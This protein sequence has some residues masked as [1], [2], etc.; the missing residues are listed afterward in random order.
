MGIL[1]Q[2]IAIGLA[3]CATGCYEDFSPKIDATPVL[4]VNSLITAGEPI[5]VEV[6]HSWVYNS[7]E[8]LSDHRVYDA[9]VTIYANGE[10]VG[11]D[12]RPSQGDEI[13]IVA[14]SEKYG[15]AEATVTVPVAIPITATDI[16][17]H[18]LSVWRD[19]AQAMDESVYFNMRIALRVDDDALTEN[20]FRVEYGCVSPTGYEDAGDI[21]GAPH[22][23]YTG[24]SMGEFEYEAEPIFK[25]HVGVF[26][27]VFGDSEEA[28]MLFSDKQF[29]GKS[30]TLNLQ[31]HNCLF[32]VEAPAYDP[33]LYDASLTFTLVT[34]SR[35]YYDR[36]IYIWQ[37]D[38]GA[39][40][41]LGDLGF[42]QPMWGYSNVSTG[43]GVVA[44]RSAYTITLPLKDY[45]QSALKQ[46]SSIPID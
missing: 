10:P 16:N 40:G 35:S 38:S 30:Y 12:F 45:L 36:L 1:K 34:I 19:E 43:A 7:Q 37:R 44:A 46:E 42:A 41:D 31:F 20:F 6:S 5:S 32:Y 33:A 24:L 26:E 25:E 13:R 11:D 4:C 29:S 21:L 39:L 8:G 9:V 27:S 15:R 17:T 2:I 3:V 28:F 23:P 18:T 14:D 22:M